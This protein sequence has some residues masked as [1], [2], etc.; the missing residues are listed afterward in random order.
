MPRL[1]AGSPVK[2]ATGHKR[3]IPPSTSS[4]TV[5]LAQLKKTTL[6][7][8]RE[9][10]CRGECEYGEAPANTHHSQESPGGAHQG[11]NRCTES[12][13]TGLAREGIHSFWD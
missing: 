9:A 3:S 11:N 6:L 4:A 8:G 12:I 7:Q 13:R 10:A 2:A 5:Q 1:G